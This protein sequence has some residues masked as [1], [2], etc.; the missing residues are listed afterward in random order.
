MKEI[1]IDFTDT[2]KS[3]NKFFNKLIIMGLVGSALAITALYF[4]EKI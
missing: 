4:L 1:T 2:K 3:I